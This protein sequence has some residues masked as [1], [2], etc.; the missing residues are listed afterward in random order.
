[1]RSLIDMPA[2]A[3]RGRQILWQRPRPHP[4]DQDEMNKIRAREIAIVLKEPMT[5]IK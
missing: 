2:R 4:A 1:V 5:A 3:V